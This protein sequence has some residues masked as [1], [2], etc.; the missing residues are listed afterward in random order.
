MARVGFNVNCN[1]PVY[2][3]Y[4]KREPRAYDMAG[5]LIF[6][7]GYTL[8]ELS[9]IADLI[10]VWIDHNDISNEDGDDE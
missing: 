3:G 5:S 8:E 6:D 1:A 4:I 9:E 10:N 7:G 2:P